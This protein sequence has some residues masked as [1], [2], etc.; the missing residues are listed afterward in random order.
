MSARCWRPE[1]IRAAL[2]EPTVRPDPAATLAAARTFRVSPEPNEH[3]LALV[4]GFA[5]ADGA[6][7]RPTTRLPAAVAASAMQLALRRA[8]LTVPKISRTLLPFPPV[9]DCRLTSRRHDPTSAPQPHL[10]SRDCLRS[11]EQP[12]S[13]MRLAVQQLA[14]LLIAD[15]GEIPVPDPNGRERIRR[16][17]ADDLV[18]FV[19]KRLAGL[20]GRD[21]HRDHDCSGTAIA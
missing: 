6:A 2:L 13:N 5:P 16:A 20:R 21:R 14:H 10:I 1:A 17:C 19:A 9:T 12:Q 4:T 8:A 18:D 11:R 15:R 7:A 3:D